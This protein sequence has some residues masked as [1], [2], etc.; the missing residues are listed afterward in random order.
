[1]KTGLSRNAARELSVRLI[2]EMG[3]AEE[4]KPE[5]FIADRLS[6]A[7]FARLNGEDPLYDNYPDDS[8]REYIIKLISGLHRHMPEIDSYIEKY[9]IGW[10]VG[11]IS[12]MAASILRICMYEVMYMPEIPTAA[13]IDAAV[14]IAKKYETGETTAFI[15][16][17]LGSF[18]R[19]EADF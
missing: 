2:Y 16:G 9:A 15:N 1:M 17:I 13:S 11:R 19:K 10:D 12:R 8:Q 7:A 6:E 4:E 14:R 3:F 18:A 5:S